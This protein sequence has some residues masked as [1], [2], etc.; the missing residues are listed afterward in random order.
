MGFSLAKVNR[1]YSLVVVP[2]LLVSVASLV[3]GHGLWGVAGFS[4]CSTWAS[5]VAALEHRLS[6][7]GSW[8]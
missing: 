6:S 5:V 8:A 3:A 1:G 2:R 7:F 4:G